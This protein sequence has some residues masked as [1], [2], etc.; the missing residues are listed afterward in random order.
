MYF[1]T[2]QFPTYCLSFI[3]HWRIHF[4]ML[5]ACYWDSV[6]GMGMNL[7]RL[8]LLYDVLPRGDRMLFPFQETPGF[9]L[10]HLLTTHICGFTELE[11][12]RSLLCSPKAYFSSSWWFRAPLAST[13]ISH[14]LSRVSQF[15]AL[16]IRLTCLPHSCLRFSKNHLPAPWACL[17]WV[18]FLGQN[19]TFMLG[20]KAYSF[21]SSCVQMHT[22]W[23]YSPAWKRDPS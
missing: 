12:S 22:L 17:S 11:G 4:K 6:S 10:N 20:C 15:V 14:N 21:P 7:G 13:F 1:L 19:E 5:A 9:W 23:L 3:K 18:Y 2:S 8:F 16:F